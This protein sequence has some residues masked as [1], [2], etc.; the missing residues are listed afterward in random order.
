MPKGLTCEARERTR[1]PWKIISADEAL[2]LDTR[3]E[4][5]CAECHG[6]VLAVEATQTL[7]AHFR[8]AQGHPG[9]TLGML[10]DGNGPRLH[11]AAVI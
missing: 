1:G 3:T 5:R 11:P 7:P 4:K 2:K 6:R 9:C 10:Y 8:H